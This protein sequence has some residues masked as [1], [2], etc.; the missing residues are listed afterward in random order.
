MFFNFGDPFP[1]SRQCTILYNGPSNLSLNIDLYKNITLQTIQDA[2]AK[3]WKVRIFHFRLFNQDGIEIFQEDLEFIRNK[4]KLYA[5]FGQDFDTKATFQEYLITKKLG[6]GGFGK[7]LL[8]QHR[9]TGLKV[10]I[11]IVNTN[12]IGNA[13]VPHHL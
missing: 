6:E 1:S 3:A 11:K 8:G 7:V 5:S 13:E 9:T 10:A 4:S 2:V 12:A